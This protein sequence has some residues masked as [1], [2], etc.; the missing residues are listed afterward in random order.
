[1]E[2]KGAPLRGLEAAFG[3]PGLKTRS[4]WTGFTIEVDGHVTFLPLFAPCQT[5]I[6]LVLR[7]SLHLYL[8][9][10]LA[11]KGQA[12]GL[13]INWPHYCLGMFD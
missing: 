11:S 12:S 13:Y 1:M 9:H 6:P 8:H 10:R 7:C 2:C 3:V 5:P 4:P